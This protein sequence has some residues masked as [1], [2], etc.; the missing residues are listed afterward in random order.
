MSVLEVLEAAG[1][2]SRLLEYMEAAGLEGELEG[3]GEGGGGGGGL[4]VY[5]LGLT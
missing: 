5:G 1:Q 2:F 4:G 3:G